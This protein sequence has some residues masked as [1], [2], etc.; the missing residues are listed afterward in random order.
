MPEGLYQNSPLLSF[1]NNRQKIAAAILWLCSGLPQQCSHSN[2]KV[3]VRITQAVKTGSSCDLE[4][5]VQT[6]ICNPILLYLILQSSLLWKSESLWWLRPSRNTL[7]IS[8]RLYKFR[9]VLFSI[10][11]QLSK[12]YHYKSCPKFSLGMSYKSLRFA[13]LPLQVML[14]EACIARPKQWNN[15][16]GC[17][18]MITSHPS[19]FLS[20]HHISNMSM[21][22]Q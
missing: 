16:E 10:I 21:R 22:S 15:S 13:V 9:K 7:L 17:I 2:K 19:F 8:F 20:C 11:K 3:H 4:H 18:W 12:H 1:S 6:S 14:C 5:E